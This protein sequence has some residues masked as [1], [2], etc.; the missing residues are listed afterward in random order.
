[1]PV[2]KPVFRLIEEPVTAFGGSLWGIDEGEEREM[3]SG[4]GSGKEDDRF[5]L[6]FGDPCPNPQE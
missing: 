4:A 3:E 1:V 6:G 5:G 2:P